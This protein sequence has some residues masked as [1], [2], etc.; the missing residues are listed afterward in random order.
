MT[1]PRYLSLSSLAAAL[2]VGERTIETWCAQGNFPLPVRIGPNGTK[3]WRWQ[4]VEEHI[5]GVTKVQIEGKI[6]HGTR[7]VRRERFIRRSHSGLSGLGKVPESSERDA[8]RLPPHADP[9]RKS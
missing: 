6:T 4:D 5:S 1:N 8:T 3:R 2:D 7:E 9:G